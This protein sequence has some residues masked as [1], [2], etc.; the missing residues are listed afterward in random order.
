MRRTR[1][2]WLSSAIFL[3][4]TT[5][6]NAQESIVEQ[7][8]SYGTFDRWCVREIK[9]SG[10][11]GG[12]TKYLYEFFGNPTDTLRT[13]KEPYVAPKG[14]PWRTNNVL[15]IVAGVVKTNN[16]VYPEKRGDGYCAR[17]ETHIE[18]VKALGIVNMD[19]TCQGVMMVGTLP[20]PIKDTKSPMAKIKYH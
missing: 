17:I 18:E 9:E 6:S 7:I 3:L 16:T 4:T 10:I 15:A 2:S 1:L 11:I 5:I 20:E 8:N 14:Y 13:G 12:K 19:V